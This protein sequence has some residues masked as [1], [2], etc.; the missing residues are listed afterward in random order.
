M[1]FCRGLHRTKVLEARCH[2][3]FVKETIKALRNL[4]HS[5][6]PN[7]TVS[8]TSSLVLAVIPQTSQYQRW[9]LLFQPLFRRRHSTND[10]FS[11]FS[12]YSVV[13]VWNH[14]PNVTVSTTSSLVSAVILQTSQYQR[15]VLLFQSLLCRRYSI[16]DEFSWFNRYSADVTISTTSSLD[17]AVIPQTSQYQRWVLLFQSLLCRRHSINDG[18][19][20]STVALWWQHEAV[21]QTSQYQ[22][23]VLLF[24]PLLCGDG[25]G[26]LPLSARLV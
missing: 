1:T 7:V 12:R 23:W 18:F 13:T 10:E 20:C 15:R 26:F 11:W 19:F 14:G 8:T 6:G 5:R 16:N 3:V 22:R 17:S 21:A 4:L 25:A 2:G 24:Q 9:V